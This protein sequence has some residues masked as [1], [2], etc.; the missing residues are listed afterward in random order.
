MLR[1]AAGPPRTRPRAVASRLEGAAD[2]AMAAAG[3]RYPSATAGGFPVLPVYAPP[4]RR[5]PRVV[6]ATGAGSAP[7]SRR[8]SLPP[9]AGDRRGPR[10]A[11]TSRAGRCIGGRASW[12]A[13]RASR[14]DGDAR[15][16]FGVVS[17]VTGG[18]TVV[19]ERPRT[20]PAAR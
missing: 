6:Y 14:D 20:L 7:R 5:R 15:A 18:K 10:A 2:R 11:Q 13:V 1:W 4:V 3:R 12:F 19:P 16:D 17:A 8:S 9:T